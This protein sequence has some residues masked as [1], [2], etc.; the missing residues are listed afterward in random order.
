MGRKVRNAIAGENPAADGPGGQ[1]G[2]DQYE[3][4]GEAQPPP[5]AQRGKRY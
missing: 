5:L 1:A 2:L 4:R 3:H